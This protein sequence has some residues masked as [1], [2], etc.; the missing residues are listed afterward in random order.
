MPAVDLRKYRDVRYFAYTIRRV[1][2]A[3]QR[4]EGGV[5]KIQNDS[6]FLVQQLVANATSTIFDAQILDTGSGRNFFDAITRA[7][8][9]F[10]TAQ[11]PNV[12]LHPKLINAN[13]Q[14]NW[15]LLDGSGASNTIEVVLHGLKLFKTV[16]SGYQPRSRIDLSRY[17][18]ADYFIYKMLTSTALGANATTTLLINIQA[19]ADFLWQKL[20]FRSTGTFRLRMSD[21]SCGMLFSDELVDNVNLLGTAQQPLVLLRPQLLLANTVIAA[22][23]TDN[24]GAGNT[25]EIGMEGTKLFIGR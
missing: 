14:L 20:V 11:R 4:D 18:E 6:D 2:T 16:P 12:L 8:L 3:S 21:L 1:L 13:A 25:I 23:I 19:D 15:T 5:T 17:V 24:S 9:V 7:A 10:G 22:T